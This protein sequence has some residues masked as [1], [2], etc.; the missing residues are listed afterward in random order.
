MYVLNHFSYG[1]DTA[2]VASHN[3][4]FETLGSAKA[5]MAQEFEKIKKL[6]GGNFREERD[7]SLSDE[8]DQRW[9]VMTERTARIQNGLDYS[10]WEI[11]DAVPEVKV[12]YELLSTV[13]EDISAVGIYD[14]LEQAQAAMREQFAAV[15]Y[16]Q[17]DD[18]DGW[19]AGKDDAGIYD[20][21]AR[22]L[23]SATKDWQNHDWQIVQLCCE[24]KCHIMS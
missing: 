22:I 1:P 2:F 19:L 12:R 5:A 17:G 11:I 3:S 6:L 21:S 8:L 9:A 7:D 24:G 10:W 14:S 20:M 13:E 4:Q 18:L 16:Y 23:D 15:A